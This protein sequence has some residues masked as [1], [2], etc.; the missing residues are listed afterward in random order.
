M[1]PFP[2]LTLSLTT[3]PTMTSN[4]SGFFYDQANGAIRWAFATNLPEICRK[5]GLWRE[6]SSTTIIGK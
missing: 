6:K 5:T 4:R 2:S 1:T 3:S